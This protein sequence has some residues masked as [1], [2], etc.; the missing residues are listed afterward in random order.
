[1]EG[2][3]KIR[4]KDYYTNAVGEDEFVY[5]T[6]EVFEALANTFRRE[7]H[8]EQMR[9]IRHLT[10]TGYIEGDTENIL[11]LIG[12]S[13]EEQILKKL[14]LERLQEIMSSL[15]SV[16]KERIFLYFFEGM[17]IRDIAK[18]QGVNRNAVWKSIQQ[19]IALIRLQLE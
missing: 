10:D 14:E 16:Q 2:L 4:L 8:A 12:E 11:F 6:K 7:E 5:V 13:L 1:M 9:D 18:V 19:A 15:S 3:I 17:T